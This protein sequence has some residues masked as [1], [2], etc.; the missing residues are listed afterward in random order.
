MTQPYRILAPLVLLLGALFSLPV[1]ASE[2]TDWTEAIPA[3]VVREDFAALYESL[4]SAHADLFAQRSRAEYDARYRAT[5]A[6][7]ITPMT[8]FEVQVAFQEFVAFGNVAHARIAFPEAAYEAFREQGGRTFPVFPRFV[9]GRAYVGDN[10]SR[11]ARIRA[12]DEIV[13]INGVPM[14]DWLARTAKHVSADTPYI[15]HSLLE[16]TFPRY[17]WLELGEVE[18]FTLTLGRDG[19]L[20]E[21]TID[22]TS[23]DAQRA[24]AAALPE[25]FVLDGSDRTF[26]MIDERIG[27]LRP[28]PF[29]S[30]E[31]P[32]RPWDNAAFVAFIDSAFDRFVTARATDLIIDL[33]HNPGGDNSFSDAMIAWFADVPF[34]FCSAFIIRSSDEAAASN[35]A[36]LAQHPDATH[37]TSALLARQYANMPRGETFEFD[38]PFSEPREGPRFEGRVYVLIDRHSYSNAVTVAAIIQDYEFGIVAGEKTSDMATTY[39]AMETFRLPNTGIEVGFPKAHIVRPSGDT[40]PDGVTPDWTIPT[41]TVAGP[42]DVVL[43][44]LV[45]RIRSRDE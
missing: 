28:G 6:T 8:R 16:F 22:A 26:R 43:A 37:S 38:I 30:V 9:D 23:R 20:I 29:Y 4:Q 42:D 11:D 7:L 18:D 27:Y 12:G 21:F 5:L 1:P 44:D 15:A 45:A 19:R 32:A 14:G 31:D 41:P 10:Y 40:R 39:G 3:D 2:E 25:S 34:R 33:R 35:A 36:R 13:A 17:L 24:A